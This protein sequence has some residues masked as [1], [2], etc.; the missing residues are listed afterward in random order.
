[1]HVVVEFTE[2]PHEYVT[3]ERLS[4][5]G[6]QIFYQGQIEPEDCRVGRDLISLS[7]IATL[8]EKAVQASLGGEKIVFEHKE[9]SW[10][11]WY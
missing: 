9:V 5:D 6:K 8:M 3:H 1:M 2:D 11:D 10:E 4:I 7:T